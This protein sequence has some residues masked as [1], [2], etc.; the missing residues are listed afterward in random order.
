[1][2]KLIVID[3]VDETVTVYPYD[4]NIWESP[5]DYTTEDGIYVLN[6]DCSWIVVDE[7]NIKIV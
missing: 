6:S 4:E 1:M 2:K 3:H 7:V 5:E